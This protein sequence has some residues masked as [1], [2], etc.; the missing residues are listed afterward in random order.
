MLAEIEKN[1]KLYRELYPNDTVSFLTLA[2]TED[3][4]DDEEEESGDENNDNYQ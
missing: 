2:D 4:D 3:D 1:R